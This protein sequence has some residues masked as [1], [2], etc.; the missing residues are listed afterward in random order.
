MNLLETKLKARIAEALPFGLL[1]TNMNGD[2]LFVNK[3]F[4][5]ITGWALEEVKDKNPRFLKSGKMNDDYYD[6]MWITL[7]AGKVWYERVANKKKDGSIYY[8]LQKVVRIDDN[9]D[10]IGFIAV[11]EDIT[12][13]IL[14]EEKH[15]ENLRFYKQLLR[16]KNE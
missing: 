14:R 4:E 5:N 10:H 8:A 16:E 13:D 9:G 6:R 2:V 1:I 12:E 3:V 11:Q 15:R 7:L